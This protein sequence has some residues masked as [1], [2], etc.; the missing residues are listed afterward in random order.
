M[1]F[2]DRHNG[3]CESQVN[4]M[5]SAIGL[6]DLD[7]LIAQTVPADIL[8]KEP[9]ALDKAV[10]EHEYIGRLKNIARKNVP[11][12][13]MIGCGFYG[14][15]TP[16]VIMRNILENPS[17][18]TSYT[19]YQAE[20]SQGRLEALLNF[21]TMIASLTGFNLAN[22]SMLDDS[23]AAAEAMRMMFELRPRAAVKEGKNVVFVDENIFPQTLSV[24]RTRARGLGIEVV[25][26][27]YKDY[28]FD[29]KCYGA[30]V[31]FPAAD[32]TVRD[33]TEFASK[34]HE[35]GATVIDRRLWLVNPHY[36]TKFGLRPRRL[37]AAVGSIPWVR[38]FFTTSCFYIIRFGA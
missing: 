19:P 12:R 7:G 32:G 33:Y 6:K 21:Q 4:E 10:S 37:W 30:I 14:T 17:W 23:T 16:A 3:P 28:A 20:I 36:E 1:R 2:A 35:A 26:G 22:C 38:D 8:L 31:Q 27:C 5:L 13:S 25:T 34:A 9:L 24:I 29:A 18:Y 15:A 11:F